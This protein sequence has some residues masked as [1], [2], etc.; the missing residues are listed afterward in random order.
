MAQELFLLLY[1]SREVNF[2]SVIFVNAVAIIY[3]ACQQQF[4]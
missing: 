4:K 2:S 3:E 1:L